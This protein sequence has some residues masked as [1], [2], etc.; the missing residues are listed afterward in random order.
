M[1]F[2][3]FN[4]VLIPIVIIVASFMPGQSDHLSQQEL[5]I[6]E[7]E[8][9]L[10]NPLTDCIVDCQTVYVADRDALIQQM[11]DAID[12]CIAAG[13]PNDPNLAHTCT[14]LWEARYLPRIDAITQTYWDCDCHCRHYYNNGIGCQN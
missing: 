12:D 2:K 8:K 13:D 6:T 11:R 7:A 5:T 9:L 10:L 1:T 4:T 3:K 14:V